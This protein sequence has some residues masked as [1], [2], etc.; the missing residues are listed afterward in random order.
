MRKMILSL[1][2]LISVYVIAV[3]QADAA[4]LVKNV[5]F[6]EKQYNVQLIVTPADGDN[7][8]VELELPDGTKY[9][10]NLFNGK[11]VLYLR[12]DNDRRWLINEAPAGK[13]KLHIDGKAA[14][15]TISIKKEKRLPVTQWVSPTNTTVVVGDET[16]ELVWSTAGDA[17]ESDEMH[18][19]LLPE[20]SSQRMHVGYTS[21]NSNGYQLGLPTSIAD[22]SYTLLLKA[23]NKTP[24]GQEIDPKVIIQVNRGISYDALQ[25]LHTESLGDSVNLFVEIPNSLRWESAFIEL[26]SADGQ[27]LKIDAEKD[28]WAELSEEDVKILYEETGKRQPEP[29]TVLEESQIYRINLGLKD[30]GVYSGTLQLAFANETMT[31]VVPIPDFEMKHRDWSLDSVKW[32]YD[33]EKI[34]VQQIQVE[35]L[36]QTDTHVQVVDGALGILYDGRVVKGLADKG[37]I[38]SF[39]IAEGDHIIE[40]IMEDDGG[41]LQSYSRRYL[42]DYTPPMLSMIQP[43][44]SHKKLESSYA[45]GFTDLDATILYEGRSYTP[46]SN[47]YFRIDGVNKSL[48]IDVRDSHGNVNHY[49]WQAENVNNLMFW[50]IIIFINMILIATAAFIIWRFRRQ[51]KKE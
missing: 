25:L 46:D 41:A 21:L 48:K 34:N 2:I 12:T 51:A 37:V 39:P 1:M 32:V 40:L 9:Q 28:E 35:L 17:D 26:S 20:G 30:E 4:T 27:S 47:G 3:G 14:D 49:E 24:D 22:G 10:P 43:Q 16:I 18:M 11:K 36:L 50:I 15:Y 33:E 29:L 5:E 31:K 44:A 6:E 13:Y 45:S 42:I 8:E 23:D 19:Y 38:I 7:F